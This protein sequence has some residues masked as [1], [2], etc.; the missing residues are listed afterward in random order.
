M[1][2]VQLDGTQQL[3]EFLHASLSQS[4]EWGH[5]DC[6]LW[7]SD[8]I[9]AKTGKD[10]GAP[11]RGQYSTKE[12]CERITVPYGGVMACVC[13]LMKDFPV[14]KTPQEGDIGVIRT[15]VGPSVAVMTP[16]GWAWK[17]ERGIAIVQASHVIAWTI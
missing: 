17:S 15:P 5:R 8:W 14:T 6:A 2:S 1:A 10:P 4:F 12:E 11:L 3:S 13:E 16:R 9:K 7:A